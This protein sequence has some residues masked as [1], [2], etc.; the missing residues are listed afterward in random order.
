MF[1]FYCIM[2]FKSYCVVCPFYCI[3]YCVVY[4]MLYYVVLLYNV[5]LSSFFCTRVGLLPPGAN[6][7]AVKIIIIK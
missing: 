7:I 2:L 3:M 5:V 4:V 6:P 1:A